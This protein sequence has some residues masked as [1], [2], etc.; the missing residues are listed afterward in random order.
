MKYITKAEIALHSKLTIAA[1]VR[2]ALTPSLTED[3][4]KNMLLKIYNKME[5]YSYNQNFR[6]NQRF[7]LS[8]DRTP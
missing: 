8:I 1:A 7:L 3:M 2:K 4:G 6:Q 5:S